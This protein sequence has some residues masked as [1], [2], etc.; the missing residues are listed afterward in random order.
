MTGVIDLDPWLEPFRDPLKSRFSK[1]Q[2]WIKKINDSEG[3]LEK[4]SRGYEKFGFTFAPNGDITY[5][6]WAPNAHKATLIGEFNNWNRDSHPLKRD[7]YGVWEITLPA[8]DGVPAIPHD[9]KIK[10]SMITP[11]GERIERIPTWIM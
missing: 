9:S 5:R 4:F 3:G 8:K 10:I 11:Q 1:A 6:E 7:S 2:D